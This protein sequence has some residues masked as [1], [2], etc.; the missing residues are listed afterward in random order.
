MTKSVIKLITKVHVVD[1]FEFRIPNGKAV[2]SCAFFHTQLFFETH[3]SSV[4][5]FRIY[6]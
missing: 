4:I 5:C 1:D 6:F 3:L 2:R